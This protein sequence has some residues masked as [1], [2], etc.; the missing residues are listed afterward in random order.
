ML[1]PNREEDVIPVSIEESSFDG[2]PNVPN[3]V[4]KDEYVYKSNEKAKS[5][6]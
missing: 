2:C 1:N 4:F 3:W 5:I 6:N